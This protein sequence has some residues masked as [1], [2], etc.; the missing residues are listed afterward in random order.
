MFLSTEDTAYDSILDFTIAANIGRTD[1]LNPS[2]DSMR[3][4][5][6]GENS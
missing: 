2:A 4:S 1:S 5:A 3:P 6:M